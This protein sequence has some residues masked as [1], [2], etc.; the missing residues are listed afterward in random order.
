M[1][2]QDWILLSIA[3]AVLT[4]CFTLEDIL[5]ELKGCKIVYLSRESR[6]DAAAVSTGGLSG[7]GGD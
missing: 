7:L 4:A 5:D 1:K 3:L 6:G 2:S